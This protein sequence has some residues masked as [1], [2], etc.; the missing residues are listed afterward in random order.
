MFFRQGKGFAWLLTIGLSIYHSN[1]VSIE[2]D[3]SIVKSSV[4]AMISFNAQPANCVALRQ[5]RKCYAQVSLQ[6]HVPKL[7]NFCI[8][9]KD[10]DSP[11]KCWTNTRKNQLVFEFESSEKIAYQLISTDNKKIIAETS[12]DVSWVHKATPRKRRWRLF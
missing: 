1:A 4:T 3:N 6:W 12:V 5:G 8:Y 10:I 7:G 11:I 2:I 9:Q